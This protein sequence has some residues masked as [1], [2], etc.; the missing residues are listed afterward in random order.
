M[1]GLSAI[2]GVLAQRNARIYY[3]GSVV[4]WTG[5]WI[6]RIATDW[7]AWELTQSALWVSVI[8]FCNLAPS[9]VISPVAGAIADRVDRVRLTMASQF[10]SVSQAVILVVLVITG[11]IRIE[12]MALL[13]FCNGTAETFAQPA[14]QCLIPGLVPRSHLPGAVALNSLTYNAAR[15][16]GPAISGPMIALWGVVPSIT[17]NA[18]AFAYASLTMV[19]LRLDPAIRHGTPT[20]ASILRDATDGMRYVA[21][22]RGIG[23]A[24]LFAATVGVTLRSVP[25]MLPPYVADIFGRDARGLATL[26]STMG[27]AALIG[28]FLI[29]IR[30]RVNGLTRIAVGCGLVLAIATAGFVATSSFTVGVICIGAIGA[31]TT[32]HGISC[33]TLLQNSASPGMIGRVL[34]TWGMITRAA[35]AMGALA[36]GMASEFLGLRIPVLVGATLCVGMFIWTWARLPSIAIALEGPVPIAAAIPSRRRR[37]A[38]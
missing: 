35:P 36:Y 18:F 37:A 13:T 11:L 4:C 23:P 38:E 6:Q 5:S 15:F 30:G 28:G 19:L 31:A 2:G 9:V 21:R 32:I 27:C 8:A 24:M 12:L 29:A 1:A 16:I 7:L 14:R 3:S 26:A 22:H 33:Q 34:S 17:V 25:E 10:V 20:G